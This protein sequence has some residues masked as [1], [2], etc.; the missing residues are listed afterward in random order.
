MSIHEQDIQILIIHVRGNEERRQ[1]MQQQLE[2]L[3]MPYTF[4]TDGNMED[5]TPDILDRYFSDDVCESPMHGIYPRTSCAY[6]HL[7]AIRHII[8]NGLEGA[9]VLEDDIRLKP[10]FKHVF[11]ESLVE[12]R[13]DH[14]HEAG[15]INYEES[16]L[17]LVPRSKRHNGQILYKAKRDRFAGCLYISRNAAEAIMQYVESKKCAYTS[18]R[19]HN[20]LIFQGLVTYYWSHPCIACQCS[21]DGSMPT[22]IPTRPR[23]LKRL[24]WFYKKIYKH[25]LYFIR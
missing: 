20:H 7:L 15:I 19:L 14:N 12:Y 13:R 24:K 10:T 1:Y 4:V 8:D 11:V 18:D 5:L 16:S 6:K 21:A 23:P 17:M 2:K 25:I 9:L 3:N 22:M